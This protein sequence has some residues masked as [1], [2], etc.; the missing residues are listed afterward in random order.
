MRGRIL[1]LLMCL[2]FFCFGFIKIANESYAK[3]FYIE[4]Y[5]VEDFMN[6]K[7]T[8]NANFVLKSDLDFFNC[9]CDFE[10]FQFNGELHGNY[11]KIKNLNLT[12][13]SKFCGLFSEI[14]YGK[15]E[16]LTIENFQ[17]YGADNS[18]CGVL[19][20]AINN[21]ELSNINIVLGDYNYIMGG[22]VGTVAGMISNS[23]VENIF[24]QGGRL[25]GIKTDYIA[26]EVIDSTITISNSLN[27][28]PEEPSNP[29]LPDEELPIEPNPDDDEQIEKPPIEDNP[30]KEEDE[31]LE[32]ENN[33]SSGEINKPDNDQTND[34]SSDLP[35]NDKENNSINKNNNVSS[36]VKLIIGL[37]ACFVILSAI[38][39]V[40]IVVV[41]NKNK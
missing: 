18:L 21:C 17:I 29:I 40:I 32:D 11:H 14:S 31:N 37:V 7:N 20:G 8:T 2:A 24:L 16:N 36:K 38:S 3:E 9:N 4:I 39:V 34:E 6:I 25:A 15:I 28:E 30:D 26:P 41:K 27:V 1:I 13:T 33:S 19:A 12:S 5:S 10:A 35:N 22:I 23:N